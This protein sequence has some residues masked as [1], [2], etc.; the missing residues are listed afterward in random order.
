MQWVKQKQTGFTIVELLIVVVVIAILAAITIVAYTGIQNRAKL[1]A[2]QSDL[3]NAAK[4]LEQFKYTQAATS[5]TELY[6]ADQTTAQALIKLSG[7]TTFTTY[8]VNNTTTPANYC[9]TLTNNAQ[10]YS[11]SSTR[12]SPTPGTCVTNLLSNTSVEQNT[13]QLQNIGTAADRTLGRTQVSDAKQG[14]Y[15]FRVTAGPSGNLSG[16]GSTSPDSLPTGRYSGSLWVR[17]N[18]S[19]VTENSYLEGSA[20]KTKVSQ[21]SAANLTVGTWAQLWYVFDITTAG[22]I[23]IGFLTSGSVPQGSSLDMDALML[24]RGDTVYQF[25]DGNSPGW[26]W[27]GAPSASTSTGPALAP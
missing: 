1:S 20:L 4:T 13:D 23:K 12:S 7:D 19:P 22:T 17:A 8:I 6:P 26:F 25:A 16:Y 24:T 21:S 15:V 18:T 5:G 2:L 14:S 3:E 10:A 27:N 9:L 11:V